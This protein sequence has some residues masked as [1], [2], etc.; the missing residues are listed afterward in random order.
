M[1]RHQCPR[2][3]RQPI[4]SIPVTFIQIQTMNRLPAL[5]VAAA[6]LLSP[7]LDLVAQNLPA[8]GT[9]NTFDVATWNIEWFGASN[10]PPNDELQ[11]ENV[12]KIMRAAEIDLWAL[13]EIA[14][15]SDFSRII[16]SLGVNY[17]GFLA[18]QS[19][20][21][22]RIGFLFDN[23][24]VRLLSQGHILES[25]SDDFASRPPLQMQAEVTIGDSSRVVTFI[26]VHMKA[27]SDQD[28][29]GKRLA[30]SGRLKNHIDFT[31][32]ED[33]PVIILGDF[34]DLINGSIT[35]GQNSPYANFVGDPDDYFFATTDMSQD[36]RNTW[37][38]SSLCSQGSTIDHILLTDEMVTYYVDN[39]T[40]HYDE[41]I[42]EVAGYTSST[43]D[44]LP[45]FA[46]FDMSRTSS[47][48][49][50]YDLARTELSIFP[51]PFTGSFS[52]DL[53]TVP[54]GQA[55]ITIHDVTGRLVQRMNSSSVRSLSVD[56]AAE[57]AGVYFVRVA[58]DTFRLSSKV[59]KVGR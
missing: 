52:L 26:T 41:V 46:R 37:C 54:L 43:S 34:N 58:G 17:T 45:V 8:K 50:E 51:N 49:E 39:S 9:D 38:S 18:T 4:A 3:H 5:I 11:I 25:F 48:E 31:S 33:D 44:H 22:Q 24:V 57:P 47:L 29:Y 28:S 35:S 1:S 56:L 21:S 23:T 15:P 32:L 42:S 20:G 30:A 27:F 14:D 12:V 10:G 40:D 2:D 59:V 53:S 16:D 13:Q 6:L 19:S 7:V 55:T 36:G